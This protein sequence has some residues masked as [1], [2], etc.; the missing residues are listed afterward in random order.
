MRRP[1]NME[2]EQKPMDQSKIPIQ[3]SPKLSFTVARATTFSATPQKD[4]FGRHVIPLT[5][6]FFIVAP[7]T[8]TK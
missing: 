8:A 2:A 5:L 1:W 3:N 6:L 7:A 4:G